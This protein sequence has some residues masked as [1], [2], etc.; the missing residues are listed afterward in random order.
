MK[1]HMK[2]LFDD[3]TYIQYLIILDH[4]AIQRAKYCILVIKLLLCIIKT[5]V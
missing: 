2:F 1:V 3:G 5:V 4:H